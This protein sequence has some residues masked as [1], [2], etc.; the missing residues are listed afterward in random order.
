M[1]GPEAIDWIARIDRELEPLQRSWQ[2]FARD[3]EQSSKLFA[4]AQDKWR[5]L[6]EAWRAF[7]AAR[8]RG[9]FRDLRIRLRLMGWMVRQI[10]DAKDNPSHRTARVWLMVLHLTPKQI[11]ELLP[12][13]FMDMPDLRVPKRRGRQKG[14]TAA[15]TLEMAKQLAARIERTGELPTT[16]AKRLLA[17]YGFRGP[18]LKGRA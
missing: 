4:A 15:S 2:S 3:I 12:Y 11:A 18:D 17:E 5:P 9:D 6:F 10:Q 14:R 13:M 7:V 1:A 8:D 16:A